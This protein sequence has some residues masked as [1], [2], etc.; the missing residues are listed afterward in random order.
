MTP[1]QER[2]IVTN[3]FPDCGCRAIMALPEGRGEAEPPRK[4][5]ALS[6][7]A[8][9]LP[10]AFAAYD[11]ASVCIYFSCSVILKTYRQYCHLP[12]A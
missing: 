4:K 7:L 2:K 5:T 9:Y 11:N 10:L 6:V 12:G 1:R 8:F 3:P